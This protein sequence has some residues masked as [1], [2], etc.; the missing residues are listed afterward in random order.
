M[1]PVFTKNQKW[2][3]N[4]FFSL[5]YSLLNTQTNKI[6]FVQRIMEENMENIL[7]FQK[8]FERILS[9]IIMGSTTFALD[10]KN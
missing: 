2:Q 1:L 10:E 5:I 4:R 9:L 7:K 8:K 6:I 3:D